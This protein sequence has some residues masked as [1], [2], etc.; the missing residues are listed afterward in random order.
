MK[1]V[2]LLSTI[3]IA[4]TFSACKKSY[5]CTCKTESTV[6]KYTA[7]MSEYETFVESANTSASTKYEKTTITYMDKVSKSN[8]SQQCANTET[9]EIYDVQDNTDANS[10]GNY[11]E[12]AYSVE[13]TGKVEC[14]L[15]KK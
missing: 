1:K 13:E 10:N 15:A 2:I 3:V 12:I 7:V 5:E 11:L 8:A 6:K 4:F 9:T 14:E